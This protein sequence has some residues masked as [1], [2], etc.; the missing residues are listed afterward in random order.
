MKDFIN[1]A[2]VLNVSHIVT[3]SKSEIATYMRVIR[4]PRGPTLTFKVLS[5]SLG[6]DIVSSL[7]RN[8]ATKNQF[9]THPLIVL[10][11]LRWDQGVVPPMHLKLMSTMLQN[12]F[13]SIYIDKVFYSL[14]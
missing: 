11:H 4:L 9:E 13:P 5:Y 3:F 10:N 12:M 2:G 6:R 8:E 1:I 7:K 14:S